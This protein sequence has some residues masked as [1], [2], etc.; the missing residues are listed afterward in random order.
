MINPGK[1]TQLDIDRAIIA[2]EAHDS[3]G[4]TES[5]GL[6]DAFVAAYTKAHNEAKRTHWVTT[7]RIGHLA[8]IAGTGQTQSKY[9]IRAIVQQLVSTIRYVDKYNKSHE[10]DILRIQLMSCLEDAVGHAYP[11]LTKFSTDLLLGVAFYP[12]NTDKSFEVLMLRHFEHFGVMSDI[13]VKLLIWDVYREAIGIT[14]G[15][16]THTKPPLGHEV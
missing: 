11:N 2:L 8:Q 9:V 16:T 6:F 1:P 7:E 15:Q 3:S 12:V 13:Q 4:I 14:P 5:N 10:L